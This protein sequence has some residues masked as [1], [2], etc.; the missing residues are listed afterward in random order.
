MIKLTTILNE[1]KVGD[2]RK[3]YTDKSK[4]IENARK[5]L[6]AAQAKFNKLYGNAG[7]E[8]DK[9]AEKFIN[10]TVK[11]LSKILNVSR[12]S[13]SGSLVELFVDKGNGKVSIHFRP[14]VGAPDNPVSYMIRDERWLDNEQ[15]NLDDKVDSKNISKF[16][17]DRINAFEKKHN[18]GIKWFK[19]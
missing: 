11:N 5:E 7:K 14:Y 9:L 13:N 1:I 19:K 18:T 4:E 16:I 8:G 15:G 6:D 2:V 12:V 17:K 3:A 10:E